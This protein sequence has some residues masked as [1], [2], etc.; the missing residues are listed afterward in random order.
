[1]ANVKIT[2]NTDSFQKQMRAMTN[3]LKNVNSNFSLAKTQAKLFGDTTDVL[4]V[5]QAELTK[6][7]EIQNKS[8]Q[9]QEQN[10]K[11]LKDALSKEKDTRDKLID[12]IN[13]T[14][15]E[16]KASVRETG[17]N[18]KESKAL[19]D[20]LRE[21]QQQYNNTEKSI[22]ATNRK[23]SAAEGKLNKN[24]SEVLEN[25]KALED[26]N[27]ALNPSKIDKFS[28]SIDKLGGKLET[29]NNKMKPISTAILGLGGVSSAFAMD[30]EDNMAD[31]NTLLDDSSS[32]EK[33]R[34][35]ILD[36]SN[37]TGL[38]INETANAFY[39]VQSSLGDIKDKEGVFK[40]ATDAAVAGNANPVDTIGL[41]SSAMKG[42]GDVS[43]ET[44]KKLS[45]FMF[46]T[47]KLGVTTVPELA[48]SMQPLFPVAKALN[49]SYEELFGTM[50]TLTG[51]TGNTSEVSTQV[52]SIFNGLLSPTE[53]MQQVMAKYGYSSGEAMIKGEG[54]AGVLRILKK[55]TGGSA[56]KLKELFS[57]QTALVGIA[58]LAGEQYDVF[59]EKERQMS[60]AYGAT[61]EALKK[62]T[63]TTKF[64]LKQSLNEL[65][66]SLISVG[67]IISPFI[68]SF[69]KV[70]SFLVGKFSSLSDG[71]KK[72][73]LGFLGLFV[74]LNLGIG[75]FR[76]LSLTVK[77]N[78]EFIKLLGSNA[79]KLFNNFKNG[80]GIIGK[81]KNGVLNTVT[82]FKNLAKNI[83][84]ST[85]EVGKNTTALI[86]N[87]GKMLAHSL[88]TKTSAK[89]TDLF[90]KANQTLNRVLNSN[91]IMIVVG[92]LLTLAGTFVYL[93]NTNENFREGV[94]AVWDTIKK[95]FGG[96]IDFF[97]GIFTTDWVETFGL[98]GIN[99][100]VFIDTVK[101]IWDK[102][103]NIFGDFI[104]FFKNIFTGNWEDAFNN[105]VDIIK[106]IFG[107]V[108][109]ILK[110]PFNVAI[111]TINYMI[112]KINGI[113]FTVPEWVPIIGGK[114]FGFNIPKIP[115]LAEGGI[116]TQPTLALV[117][118][119]K[120]HEAVV[121]LS[122]LDLLVNRAVEKA[123][124]TN[125]KKEAGNYFEVIVPVD[126]K[127]IAR[128]MVDSMGNILSKNA[129]GRNIVRGANN[130]R[131]VF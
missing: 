105:L 32:L 37:E 64:T 120:E 127:A 87:K 101:D 28:N 62:K 53:K 125:N 119:G 88:I 82:S 126:G 5:K 79:V 24:K 25:K 49:I 67:D 44:A 86:L 111:D 93:Y 74:G 91:P 19:S 31:I 81:L 113:S 71:S 8:I 65:K 112:E 56:S 92:L 72:A 66:N 15:E 42:Y 90:R 123:I 108:G 116:I 63:D 11:K 115:A 95:I 39:Q 6:K 22:E 129:N 78:V 48:S 100:Q 46:M 47:T 76:K 20:K 83:A 97:K 104:D 7:I 41:I 96:F 54:L 110:A 61:D 98:L 57:D 58:S 4:K 51:V 52:M 80:T 36:V 26:M 12:K 122:K 68:A 75:I 14:N 10:L 124:K 128:V 109:D 69:A 73:L 3:E 99:F 107:I 33:Y 50:A 27:K 38:G 89:A 13:K 40:V 85:L 45:D 131:Y 23:L 60:Q 55:E 121:P 117:G 102:I 106:N 35:T 16:Y 30:F 2:A 70:L 9:L 21:L 34:Q 1:M 84:S 103:K 130:V 43:E 59:L 114:H 17:K 118:E 94:K 77:N 18:S 29:L